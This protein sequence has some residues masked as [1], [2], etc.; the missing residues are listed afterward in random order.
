MR[1]SPDFKTFVRQLD[2]AVPRHGKN[3]E[4]PLDDLPKP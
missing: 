2:R 1:I 4:L 3:Y